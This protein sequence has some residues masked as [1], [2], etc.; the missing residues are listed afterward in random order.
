MSK[1]IHILSG[2]F[3]SEAHALRYTQE[4]W[5]AEPSEGVSDE[6][7]SLWEDR[8]PSWRLFVELGASHMDSSFVETVYGDDIHRLCRYSVTRRI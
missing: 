6:E 4:Q 5:E 2:K 7:Y 1:T 3:A 8:N